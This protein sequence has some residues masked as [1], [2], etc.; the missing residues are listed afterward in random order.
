[1]IVDN[2]MM[3]TVAA[4]MSFTPFSFGFEGAGGRSIVKTCKETLGTTRAAA[5]RGEGEGDEEKK[6][7]RAGRRRTTWSFQ[8]D[9]FD[10][11]E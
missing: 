8:Q 1:M 7:T 10:R 4:R 6:N 9:G 11:G 2:V 5:R 3:K